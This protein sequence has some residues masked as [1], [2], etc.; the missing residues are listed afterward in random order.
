MLKVLLIASV[1]IG[2]LQNAQDLVVQN[3][4]TLLVN[5]L[6][7][8]HKSAQMLK[9]LCAL[10]NTILLELVFNYFPFLNSLVKTGNLK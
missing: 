10:C 9:H 1:F 7:R 2:I 6:S 3:L 8:L 4:I 5:T